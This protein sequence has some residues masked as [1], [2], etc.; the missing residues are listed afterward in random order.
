LTGAG[1]SEVL[2]IG[3]GPMGVTT[4]LAL[5]KSGVRV[6]MVSRHR[7]ISNTPRAHIT[8]QRTMEVFRD[9]SVARRIGEVASPWDQMGDTLFTTS[10]AGPEIARIRAWGTGDD[11]HGQY[12]RAS[13]EPMLDVTQPKLESVVLAAAL[14]AGATVSFG[15]EYLSHEQDADGVT[16]RLRD[17]YTGVE[18]EWRSAYLVGADGARSQVID[19]LGLPVEGNMGRATTAYVQFHA[20]LSSYTAH[21]PSI[22]YWILDATAAYGEIGMGLLRAVRPWT[23]WIAGWG[24]DPDQGEPDFSPD[25]VTER[26]RRLVGDP[27]LQPEILSTSVWQVNEAY[28]STLGRGRVFCGGDA[29]HRHPPSGGLGSNTSVQDA[30]NLAWKLA[31][32][33]RGDAGSAL[34]DSYTDERAPVARQIVARA[35]QSRR[36]FAALREVIADL[37]GADRARRTL[38]EDPGP[39][40]VE[41]RA[42]LAAALELKHHEFNA[43]GVESNQQYRSAAVIGAPEA[44]QADELIARRVCEPGAKLPHAWLVGADGRRVST[45]DVVGGGRFAL[46]TGI[47][48]L[49]WAE[50]AAALDP[51]TIRPVVIGAPG[52]EDLYFEWAAL[53][54]GPEDGAILVRPDGYVAWMAGSVSDVDEAARQLDAALRSILDMGGN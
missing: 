6:H 2:V 33:L 34:L 46:I 52:S 47:S 51:R 35:N 45:L 36:D 24:F 5:A 1:L 19:D 32:V 4:A 11:Q 31:F 48:G 26:I 7:W 29:I 22:L 43:Q 3:T 9:L 40:A 10:F 23:E 50:A 8:N 30:F 42:K 21:R 14:E 37:G 17:R 20:D 18:S 16:T 27:Q 53:R 41:A 13:P 38:A 49:H 28:A 44:G 15:V 25:A 39:D 12:V 54:P